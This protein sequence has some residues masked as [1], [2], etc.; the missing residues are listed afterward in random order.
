MSSR[1]K[2]SSSN[3]R[4]AQGDQLVQLAR[5]TRDPKLINLLLQINDL[6]ILDVVTRNGYTSI[7]QLKRLAQSPQTNPRIL[8]KIATMEPGKYDEQSEFIQMQIAAIKTLL[9]Q[10]EAEDANEAQLI[11]LHTANHINKP[12]LLK[13]LSESGEEAILI[14]IAHNKHAPLPLLLELVKDDERTPRALYHLAKLSVKDRNIAQ[15]HN[16]RIC[17]FK[18]IVAITRDERVDE[19]LREDAEDRLDRLY[20][21]VEDGELKLKLSGIKNVELLQSL[22]EDE[23][24]PLELLL[25]LAKDPETPLEILHYLKKMIGAD[26]DDDD[27]TMIN[28]IN[29]AATNTL[30]SIS[31]TESNSV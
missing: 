7:E 25:E 28:T 11:C 20:Q 27:E 24:T 12:H 4:F 31:S 1:N 26:D 6:Q 9:K 23:N 3:K 21:K 14:G 30:Q 15:I 19:E 8:K 2:A 13:T 29:T 18:R 10:A 5:E 16:I 22:I 17:A